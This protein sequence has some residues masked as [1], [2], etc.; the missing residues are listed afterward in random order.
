MSAYPTPWQQ[1][2]M[3][4][5]L[6]ALF[7]VL[8]ILIAGAVVYVG[9]NLISFLQPILIPIAVAVILSYL[10]DPLVTELCRRKFPRGS[11]IVIIFVSVLIA[12]T[13]LFWWV[14]PTISM[15][16]ANFARELPNYTQK[17]RDRIVDLIVQYN[18][19]VGGTSGREKSASS[20]LVNFLLGT[21]PPHAPSPTPTAAPT[22]SPQT[23]TSPVEAISAAPAKISSAERQQL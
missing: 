12:L 15:Q 18:R 21:P 4:A 14:V 8:L 17:A 13:G 10:L 23:T 19:V 2:T 11:A 9:A 6:T 7:V 5:A 1:R 16:S 20:G 3:W 22:P